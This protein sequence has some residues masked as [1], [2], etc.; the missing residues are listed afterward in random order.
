MI[1]L[2]ISILVFSIVSWESVLMRVLIKVILMP[3][4]AGIMYE[5]IKITAK[6]QNKVI[7][8]FILPG[9]CKD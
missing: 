5:I 8:I 3:L 1:M 6:S 7:Q 9:G 2:L 4:I